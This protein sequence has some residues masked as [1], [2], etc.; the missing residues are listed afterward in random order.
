ML[1]GI[2]E[3]LLDGGVTRVV[4]VASSALQAQF[5]PFPRCVEVT[6]NDDPQSEMIDSIRIGLTEA[7]A[8]AGY[9]VCPSDAAGITAGDVRRCVDAFHETPDRII[10]ATHGG[11][12]GHPMIVPAT[13][14]P[15]VHS[16]EC[17]TGLNHLA[18]HRAHLVREVLCDSPG[19]VANVN[20][21]GDYEQLNDRPV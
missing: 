17:D 9:L 1:L 18:R 11:R 2:V 3:A 12:R 20:T 8:S 6:L 15:V 14:A 19:T 5:P 7:T 16:V 21:P 13:L 10:I 4:V